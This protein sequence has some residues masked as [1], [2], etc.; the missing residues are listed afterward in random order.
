MQAALQAVIYDL[1]QGGKNMSEGSAYNVTA[2]YGLV[3][4]FTQDAVRTLLL[5]CCHTGL[6]LLLHCCHTVGSVDGC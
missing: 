2:V 3:V 6:A 4:T 5:H 1:V